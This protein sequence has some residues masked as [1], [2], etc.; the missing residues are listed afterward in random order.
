M[1][2]KATNK[3][4]ANRIPGFLH[5]ECL[6]T[7]ID[8]IPSDAVSEPVDLSKGFVIIADSETTGNH[9]VLDCPPAAG[10]EFFKTPTGKRYV[11]VDNTTQVRCVVAD[12]HTAIPMTPGTYEIG[13]QQEYDYFEQA[14]R[15]V[16]D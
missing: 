1:K 3:P 14:A 4:A 10:V 6:V 13:F 12:R 9:H 5:G 15:N 16:R 11:K 7:R 8:S 2:R